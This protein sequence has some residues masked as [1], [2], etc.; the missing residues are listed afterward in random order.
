M[1]E[2]NTLP[3]VINAQ[4]VGIILNELPG[5]LLKNTTSIENARAAIQPLL[6]TIEAE[7]MNPELDAKCNAIL[8]KLKTTYSNMQEGRKP[9]TQIMNQIVK[10]FTSL[11]SEIDPKNSKGLYAKIQACRDQY[12]KD[13]REAQRKREEE[14]A[15]QLAI[16]RERISVK[17]FLETELHKHFNSHLAL[18]KR[19]LNTSLESLKLTHFE[20]DVLGINNFPTTYDHAHFA[21]F[22]DMPSVVYMKAEEIE[23]IRNDVT[24]GMYGTFN[25]TYVAE[26]T[27]YKQEITDKIPSKKNELETIAENA[28][29]KAIADEAAKKAKEANDLAAQETAR[30]AQEKA[31]EEK[32]ILD[33]AAEKRQEEERNRIAKEQE[34]NQAIASTAVSANAMVEESTVVVQAE[35]FKAGEEIAPKVKEGYKIHVLNQVGFLAIVQFYMDKE[36]NKE[37]IE[38]LE[39]KTLGAMVK[40]AEKWAFIKGEFIN[41][42]FIKYEEVIKA[43]TTKTF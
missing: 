36:G 29:Q 12:A 11:E 40:V 42:P 13:M 17:A 5:V 35:L 19:E 22:K 9:A 20:E 6:D 26:I 43:Q 37:S 31:A 32:R 8:V 25:S 4:E 23:A 34:E 2:I 15:K 30:I 1:G 33:L 10:Q 21:A 24:K 28:R 14:A 39:K 18:K 16:D 7:G 41:N 38:K 3:E 27:L